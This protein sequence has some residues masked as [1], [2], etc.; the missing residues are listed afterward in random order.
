[1]SEA[2]F[3]HQS[4]VIDLAE[5]RAKAGPKVYSCGKCQEQGAMLIKDSS[6]D[7]TTSGQILCGNE[8]CDARMAADWYVPSNKS[9]I[10][11]HMRPRGKVIDGKV[12]YYCAYCGYGFFHM[13]ADGSFTCFNEKCKRTPLFR[14]AWHDNVRG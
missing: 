10:A 1:M 4:Q 14:W 6:V 5:A 3:F 11:K 12:Q 8:T 2:N 7:T 13:Q 9:S